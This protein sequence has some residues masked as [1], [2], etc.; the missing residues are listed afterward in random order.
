MNDDVQISEI[1]RHENITKSELNKHLRRQIKLYG[2][3]C[4]NN[5]KKEYVTKY[6]QEHNNVKQK[7]ERISCENCHCLSEHI[8]SIKYMKGTNLL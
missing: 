4:I 8:I 3:N 6:H 7:A 5:N 1:E 2:D